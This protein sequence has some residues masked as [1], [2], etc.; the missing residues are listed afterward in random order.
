[1]VEGMAKGKSHAQVTRVRQVEVCLG[2]RL[3][4]L[5]NSTAT[6]LR[7]AVVRVVVACA[8]NATWLCARPVCAAEPP[9]ETVCQAEEGPCEAERAHDAEEKTGLKEKGPGEIHKVG[10][11]GL[12]QHVHVGTG[13]LGRLGGECLFPSDKVGLDAAHVGVGA[14]V[15]VE[16]RTCDLRIVLVRV[17]RLMPHAVHAIVVA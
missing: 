15:D 2:C 6:Y 13:V 17:R 10:L 8:V 14:T 4:V 9:S 5:G 1:M 11:E 12:E 16:S 7:R 3:E